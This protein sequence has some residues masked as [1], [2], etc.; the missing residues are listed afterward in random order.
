MLTRIRR[1]SKPLAGAD[2]GNTSG[3]TNNPPAPG[4]DAGPRRQISGRC[5]EENLPWNRP[6]VQCG[7]GMDPPI[8]RFIAD[9]R[10]LEPIA[11]RVAANEVRV[12][13]LAR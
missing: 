6:R 12:D 8:K 7:H 9:T 4:D 2:K 3:G 5:A 10:G 1:R 11:N 13:L